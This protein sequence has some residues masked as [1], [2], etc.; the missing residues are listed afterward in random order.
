MQRCLYGMGVVA[1]PLRLQILA[2]LDR[3]SAEFVDDETLAQRTE[4]PIAE[5]RQQLDILRTE[6]LITVSD[7]QSTH[8]ARISPAGT[9]AIDRLTEA[10]TMPGRRMS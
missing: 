5:I 8:S 4:A 1:I 6:D 9:R 2:H 10:E 7:T 3:R